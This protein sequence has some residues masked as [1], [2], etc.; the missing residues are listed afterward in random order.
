MAFSKPIY[1]FLSRTEISHHL[2]DIANLLFGNQIVIY[3][4]G[5]LGIIW[6]IYNYKSY[7]L[8]RN[9]PFKKN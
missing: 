5:L 2:S 4:I 6:L 1:D 3:I 7:V 9:S 8:F